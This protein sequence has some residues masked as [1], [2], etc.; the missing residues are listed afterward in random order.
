MWT[1]GLRTS[2][3]IATA[4][5]ATTMDRDIEIRAAARISPTDT[6]MRKRVS[7][8]AKTLVFAAAISA[9]FWVQANAGHAQQSG[10]APSTSVPPLRIGSGDLIEVG[11]YDSRSEERRVGKECRSRW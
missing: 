4:C 8:M 5:T 9:F 1:C 3:P 10:N 11:V 7:D 6:K 2:T